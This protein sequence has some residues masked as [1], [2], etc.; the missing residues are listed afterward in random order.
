VTGRI[1]TL[2]VDDEPLARTRLRLM[3]ADHTDV[4]IIGEAEDAHEAL[5]TAPTA[6]PHLIFLDVQMPGADGFDVMSGL[7][8]VPRPFVVFVTAHAEHA[9]RAFD[10]DAVDYLLKPYDEERLAR[11]LA[12]AR[13]AIEARSTDAL[14]TRVRALTDVLQDNLG[15]SGLLAHGT[16]APILRESHPPATSPATAGSRTTYLTRFTV[17]VG[18]RTVFVS[19]EEVDWIES[20]RNYLCLHVGERRYLVRAAIGAIEQALDPA[21]FVRVHRSAIVRRDRVRELR[22]PSGGELRAV[23]TTGATVPVGVRYKER[24]LANR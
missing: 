17:T 15:R 23:L 20:D 12:R 2:I 10:V 11:A 1:R 14:V 24:L 16:P 13:R 8:L 9:A 6:C 19:A 22:Q 4:E 3:L 5:A 18:R 7:S 21:H